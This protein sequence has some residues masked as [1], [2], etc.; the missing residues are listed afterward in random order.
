MDIVK[1]RESDDAL[2]NKIIMIS[3]KISYYSIDEILDK[4]E[5]LTFEILK[6]KTTFSREEVNFFKTVK[7]NT[8]KAED[9]ETYIM[10]VKNILNAEKKITKGKISILSVHSSKGL[11]WEAVFIPTLLEG[12]FPSDIGEKNIEEEKRLFY[13][14]CSRG[15][16]YLYLLYPEYFYEKVGYFNKKSS[17]LK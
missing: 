4:C 1:R 12:I 17:F 5:K 3:N 13:V 11:E 14:A 2:L 9:L 15:K 10:E 8:K 7:N 6:I 16:K